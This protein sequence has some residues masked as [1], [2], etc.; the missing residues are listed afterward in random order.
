MN[1]AK[2]EEAQQPPPFYPDEFQSD[3][4]ECIEDLGLS[5]SDI[6]AENLRFVY[7]YLIRNMQHTT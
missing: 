4:L 5:H 3:A 6:S 7:L 1:Q 2:Q